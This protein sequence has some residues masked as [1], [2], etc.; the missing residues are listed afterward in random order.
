MVQ[1][2]T[3]RFNKIFDRIQVTKQ[4]IIRSTG[5][6][7]FAEFMNS[8]GVLKLLTD[9]LFDVRKTGR[10]R[11]PIAEIVT[12]IILHLIDG[13][14]RISTFGRNPNLE[15][16]ARMFGKEAPHPTVILNALKANK[17]LKRALDKVILR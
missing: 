11:F 13:D 17:M 15:L 7:S 12:R 9:K 4:K 10:V 16:F 14:K 1:N 8:I 3:H 6:I 5:L 2:I